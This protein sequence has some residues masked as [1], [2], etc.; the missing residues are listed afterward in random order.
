MSNGNAFGPAWVGDIVDAVA[1]YDNNGNKL[2]TQCYDMIKGQKVP[3]WQDTAVLITWDDWGG[4]YDHV[5]PFKILLNT[6][7]NPCTVW[8]CGY[9]YGF[10]V[11]FMFV[12]AYTPQGFVSGTVN[13]QNTTTCTDTFHCY[14]FGSI[15]KFIESNFGLTTVV[16]PPYVYAD[17]VANTLDKQFYSLATARTFT[18]IPTPVPPN[19]FINPGAPNCIPGYTGPVDPDDDG[20]EPSN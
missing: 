19:C 20:I 16:Q 2:T 18:P 13:L 3:Y 1:G 5:E 12:S 7:Q 10:R 6:K 17:S 14:D 15:L 11:P 9:V 4:W 8:G